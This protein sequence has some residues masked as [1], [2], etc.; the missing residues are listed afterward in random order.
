MCGS[1]V[2][3][4]VLVLQN[5]KQP[6]ARPLSKFS[7]SSYR[8]P[9]SCNEKANEIPAIAAVVNKS[10]NFRRMLKKGLVLR[11]CELSVEQMRKKVNMTSTADVSNVKIILMF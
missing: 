7:V 9:F 1:L 4:M 5:S 8:R 11:A 3:K 2:L 6:L 10:L